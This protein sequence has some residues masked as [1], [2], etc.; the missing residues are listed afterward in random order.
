V[1]RALAVFPISFIINLVRRRSERFDL[2][3]QTVMWFSGASVSLVYS[4]C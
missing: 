2:P 1:G 4:E 3:S